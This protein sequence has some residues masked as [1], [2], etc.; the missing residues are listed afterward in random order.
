MFEGIY[1]IEL[2]FH[3]I[4]KKKDSE[5]NLKTKSVQENLQFVYDEPDKRHKVF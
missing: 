4:Q 2:C 3:F 5:K 1:K